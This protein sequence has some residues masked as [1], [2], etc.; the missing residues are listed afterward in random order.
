MN[1]ISLKSISLVAP[2]KLFIV[3]QW[4]VETSFGTIA[5]EISKVNVK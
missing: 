4:T 1:T 3:S 5:L 2:L